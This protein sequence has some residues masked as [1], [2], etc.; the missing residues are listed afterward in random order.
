MNIRNPLPDSEFCACHLSNHPPN[1]KQLAGRSWNYRFGL[2]FIYI[3][4]YLTGS[5]H[6][7]AL[8]PISPRFACL[9]FNPAGSSSVMAVPLHAVVNSIHALRPLTH[10]YLYILQ[11]AVPIRKLYSRTN[12]EH[13]RPPSLSRTLGNPEWRYP[14]GCTKQTSLSHL[15]R[16]RVWGILVFPRA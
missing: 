16:C 12:T 13:P 14:E 11:L 3:H 15:L 1:F 2:V 10:S 7:Q 4:L 9:N 8:C 6:P 5:H